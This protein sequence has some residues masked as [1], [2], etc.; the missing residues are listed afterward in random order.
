MFEENRY[1]VYEDGKLDGEGTF[2][3]TD[4]SITIIDKDGDKE[5]NTLRWNSKSEF[6]LIDED[7][8]TINGAT[9]NY[10]YESTFKKH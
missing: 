4:N 5:V 9:H 10:K 1:K 6:V 3:A 2:T 8:E 7:T